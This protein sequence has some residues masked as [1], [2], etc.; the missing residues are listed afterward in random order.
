MKRVVVL[1]E[2]KSNFPEI[3]SNFKRYFEDGDKNLI[4]L[5]EKYLKQNYC[6]LYNENNLDIV[7]QKAREDKSIEIKIVDTISNFILN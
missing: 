1:K 7:F 5:L 2:Y 6:E 4:N 3:N